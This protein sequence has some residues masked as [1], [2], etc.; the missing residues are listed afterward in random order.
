MFPA[1]FSRA[2]TY[3]EDLTEI[4]KVNDYTVRT[5]FA[6]VKHLTP[7]IAIDDNINVNFSMRRFAKTSARET[8]I[9]Y[10]IADTT[11]GKVLAS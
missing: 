4:V 5:P 10:C 7:G 2:V 3:N 8:S 6:K 1:A 11:T 9:N